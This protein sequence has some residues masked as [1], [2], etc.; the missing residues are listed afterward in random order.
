MTQDPTCQGRRVAAS[1]RELDR[2]PKTHGSGFV[3]SKVRKNNSG[4]ASRLGSKMGMSAF[5]PVGTQMDERLCQLIQ[6]VLGYSDGSPEQRQAMNRLLG[7][8]PKLPGI[9][10]DPFPGVDPA[11]AFNRALLG[12]SCTRGNV[13]GHN[14]RRFVE[15][16]DLDIE[17]TDAELVRKLFIRWFN[18]ILKR[19]L[20]K[21]YRENGRDLSLNA[22]IDRSAGSATFEEI[23]PDPT[24]S[25]LDSLA[26]QELEEANKRLEQDLKR[27][28]E[29][30]P[31]GKLRGCHPGGY[32]HCNCQELVKRRI[33]QEPKDTWKTI[34]AELNVP[35]GTVTAHW[36]R[37]CQPLLAEIGDIFGR[38]E[39]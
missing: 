20:S 21:V 37:K 3:G 31:E 9:Y 18:V 4:L 13:S 33:L 39:E 26:Q 1:N 7:L 25:G 28:I 6:E 19:Q 38:P 12:V 5:S 36:K 35:Q 22:P 23:L 2:P 30:D 10:M 15:K 32:P 29:E 27:Y 14:L 24:V 17:N 11:D 8:I 16:R 34:S